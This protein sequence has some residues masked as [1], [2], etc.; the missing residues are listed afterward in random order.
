M[1]TLGSASSAGMIA[2][3]LTATLIW[4]PASLTNGSSVSQDVTVQG[5]AV[6]DPVIAG[7]SS[8]AAAGWRLTANVRATNTVSV[9][10]TNNTG[11][12]VDLAAGTLTVLVFKP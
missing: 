10:L 1:P 11:G 4:N 5:A 6:G 9:L 12:T 8:I 2:T 7:F 3:V